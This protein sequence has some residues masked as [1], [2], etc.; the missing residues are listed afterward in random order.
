[1]SADFV[2]VP[3]PNL[4][5]ILIRVHAAGVMPTESQWYPTT[6]RRDGE[7]RRGAIPGY[8]FSGV[9]EAVAPDVDPDQIE[10]KVYGMNDWFTAGATAEYCQS[11][12]A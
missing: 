1:M 8:E 11:V 4:G 9:I 7:P 10:R 12:I 6:H 5:E 2:P 3:Q